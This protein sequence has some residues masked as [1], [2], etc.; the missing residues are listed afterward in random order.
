MRSSRVLG[1]PRRHVRVKKGFP[2]KCYGG[3]TRP[4]GARHCSGAL[5]ALGPLEAAKKPIILRCSEMYSEPLRDSILSNEVNEM[6][7]KST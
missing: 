4:A 1:I 7:V 5:G 6:E 2:L 3:G